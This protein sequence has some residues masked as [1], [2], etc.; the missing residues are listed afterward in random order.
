VSDPHSDRWEAAEEGSE[1]LTEG[2]VD[3]AIG[4]LTR[5][6]ERHPDNEYAYYFLGQAYY[7]QQ[8]YD[9]ALKAYVKA[10]ELQPAYLGAIVAAAHTLRMMGHHDQALRMAKQAEAKAKDDP[11]VLYVLGVIH[12]HRG[13]NDA[14]TRY[15]VRFLETR[16]EIEV[17]IEVEG[18]LQ[19]VRGEVHTLPGAGDD[20]EN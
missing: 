19:V 15:L 8:H 18:M 20:V 7:E 13:D 16:P 1:L 10:L 11:D 14:A 5:A 9:R 12:F 6:I 17:A 3:E 4:V 2:R